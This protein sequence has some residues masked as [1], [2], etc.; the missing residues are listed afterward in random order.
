MVARARIRAH[1][2]PTSSPAL[3]QEARLGW[4]D[5]DA[6]TKFSSY[7]PRLV[8]TPEVIL[9][10]D[11][12]TTVIR[13][14]GSSAQQSQE[15]SYIEWDDEEDKRSDSPFF[16]LKKSFT[17]LRAAE[18]YLKDANVKNRLYAG[19][20]YEEAP[21]SIT[22][23][24]STR[25]K[26]FTTGQNPTNVLAPPRQRKS[27]AS[28]KLSGETDTTSPPRASAVVS[29]A[30]PHP[31]GKRKRGNTANSSRRHSREV[32]KK[33]AKTDLMGNLVRKL[34][35]GKKDRR[36]EAFL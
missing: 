19:R 24:S 14:P 13:P 34:L 17:D 2:S 32:Q 21:P 20:P 33:K 15:V 30:T 11:I 27:S 6:S 10:P 18:R 5:V 29:V 26:T 4:G 9:N 25:S 36:S 16:R 7:P 12:H 1:S 23:V 31:A 22:P 35:G 28:K 8:P 3:Y